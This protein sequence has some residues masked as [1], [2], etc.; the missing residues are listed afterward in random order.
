MC[1]YVREEVP[2]HVFG[3][4][5]EDTCER[6]GKTRPATTHVYNNVCDADCNRCGETR[7]VPEHVYS[8]CTDVNCN[9]CGL[10]REASAHVIDNK[11]T[12]N[13]CNVC[14]QNIAVA[15]HVFG[16]WTVTVE[17][18]RKAEGQ[19]TRTCTG[20]GLVETA[21]IDALG[22]IGGGA[23]AAISTG[24]V[25]L[26]GAGG[27]GIYWFLIQKKTFAQL[28]AALGKGAVATAAVAGEAVAEAG[29]AAEAGAVAAEAGAEAAAE[30]TAEAVAEAAAETIA[31]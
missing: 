22:G 14:G 30:A 11:C 26:S 7:E 17:P 4:C 5:G 3:I 28:L 29:V 31:E 23:I 8:G 25:A 12:D 6:C 2:G 10:E 19:Q 1:D 15:G 13:I 20:C 21:T 18:T 16:A 9:N 24:S 27:F